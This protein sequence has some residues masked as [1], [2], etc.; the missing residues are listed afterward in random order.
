MR[1]ML[2]ITAGL[3]IGLCAIVPAS[4]AHAQQWYN[5]TQAVPVAQEP[6]PE[7]KNWNYTL[8]AGVGY[9]PTY[10][11]SDEYDALPV[12]VVN[13]EYKDGLFFTNTSNGIGSYPLRGENYKVGASIGYA[14]G[15]NEDDDRKNLRGMGDVDASA[16]ANFLAEYDLGPAQL[17]GKVSTA[18]SGDYGTTAE[19]KVG[20]RYW[21]SEKIILSGSIGTKWADEEHMSNYFGVSSAQSTRSGYSRYDAESGFKS[22]GFSVGATYRITD[23]WN[24]NLTFKGDQLVGDAADSPIV[25]DDFVPSV[26]LTTSYKF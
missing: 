8:G 4:G 26:F 3:A 21:V 2:N 10:E 19:L 6:A 22:V 1:N 7:T 18:L 23:H 9:A 12:P 13:I 17:A 5:N 11:G 25:K 15:R 24:T 14:G 20:S 16:T